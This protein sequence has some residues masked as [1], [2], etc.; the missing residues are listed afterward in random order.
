MLTRTALYFKI[1]SGPSG[2]LAQFLK[3]LLFGYD[4]IVV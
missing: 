1:V 4:D 3:L 2:Y